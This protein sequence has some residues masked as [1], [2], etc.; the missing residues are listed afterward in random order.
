M[1]GAIY[2]LQAPSAF[3][4]KPVGMWNVYEIEVV[5]PQIKGDIE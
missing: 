3:A 2:D 4:S 1:T 5:G